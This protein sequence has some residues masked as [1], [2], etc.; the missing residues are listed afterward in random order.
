MMSG[1]HTDLLVFGI[2]NHILRYSGNII[3]HIKWQGIKPKGV[4]Y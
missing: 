1:Q 2:V 3:A 4:S